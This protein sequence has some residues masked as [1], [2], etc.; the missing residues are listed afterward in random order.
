MIYYVLWTVVGYILIK[1]LDACPRMLGGS[2]QLDKVY[3]DWPVWDKPTGLDIFYCA[4]IGYHLESTIM[5]VLDPA[6]EDFCEMLLHHVATIA[7]TLFS[8]LANTT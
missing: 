1:D 5:F 7:V 6:K 2:G 8:Y 3:Q 4:S